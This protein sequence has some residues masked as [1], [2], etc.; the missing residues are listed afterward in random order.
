[1]KEKKEGTTEGEITEV[2]EPA[3]AAVKDQ[4]EAAAAAVAEEI[5]ADKR[6]RD[7]K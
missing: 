1:V 7:I 5:T 6:N 2:A 4:A 3:A